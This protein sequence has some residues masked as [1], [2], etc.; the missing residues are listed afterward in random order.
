ATDGGTIVDGA[1]NVNV[2]SGPST[3]Y[4]VV[5]TVAQGTQVNVIGQDTSGSWLSV[6]LPDGTEGWIARFL[7]NF[8]GTAA[9]AAAPP[10]VQ[11]PLAP[12]A[13]TASVTA[14]VVAGTAN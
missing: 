8:T 14:G 3:A 11:P 4:P 7:T 13:T 6:R 5:M 10:V 12:P 9:I 1:V 2:R